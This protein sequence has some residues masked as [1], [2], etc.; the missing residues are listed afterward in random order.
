MPPRRPG[1]AC[2][3][4]RRARG[5]PG[6]R[7]AR[8]DA[9]PRVELR[10]GSGTREVRVTA[11]AAGVGEAPRDHRLR[12]VRARRRARRPCPW[13]G[14]G[15]RDRPCSRT[16][17]DRAR[18]RDGGRTPAV[19]A[20]AALARRHADVAGDAAIGRAERRARRP[21]AAGR[22][23]RGLLRRQRR[24]VRALER[25]ATPAAKFSAYAAAARAAQQR[26]QAATTSSRC[27]FARI[28]SV[29]RP[30]ARR[31]VEVP[32]RPAEVRADDGQARRSRR[33]SR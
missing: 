25:A 18:R 14:P 13:R 22:E 1:A 17:P 32:V 3:R 26:R 8:P 7:S 10:A 9:R 30:L 29:P 33:G 5:T 21:G 16:R 20:D 15:R 24:A 19:A 27:L 23:R 2:R 31:P 6:S 4:G 11:A 12:P 28:I